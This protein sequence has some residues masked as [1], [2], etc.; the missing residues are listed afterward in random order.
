MSEDSAR[1]VRL[2]MTVQQHG[3]LLQ[4]AVRSME[5]QTAINE[6]LANHIDDAKRIWELLENHDQRLSA[7]QLQQTEVCTFCT[8]ARKVGW[9]IAIFA[10]GGLAYLIKFWADYHAAP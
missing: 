1:L 8:S 2:E 9:A 10:S 5:A 3:E 4:R 6:R 7:L